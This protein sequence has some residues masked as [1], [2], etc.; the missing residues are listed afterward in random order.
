MSGCYRREVIEELDE[1][2]RG[3]QKTSDE[4]L[5]QMLEEYRTKL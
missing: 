3:L 5:R 4:E 2:R 1:R